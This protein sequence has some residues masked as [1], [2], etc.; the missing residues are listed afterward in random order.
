MRAAYLLLLGSLKL[1]ARLSWSEG[2]D[3]G[4]LLSCSLGCVPIHS[5][6]QALVCGF[7]SILV[8]CVEEPLLSCGFFCVCFFFFYCSYI[9][10]IEKGGFPLYTLLTS[11]LKK[12][13]SSQ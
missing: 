3:C 7:S 12:N 4:H 8:C 6:L 1:W 10:E 5:S 2:R 11:F 9:E 13:F